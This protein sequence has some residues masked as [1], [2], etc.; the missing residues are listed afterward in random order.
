MEDH[1]GGGRRDVGGMGWGVCLPQREQDLINCKKKGKRE[2]SRQE[3]S[4]LCTDM[5]KVELFY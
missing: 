5:K 2:S 3:L 4:T 1:N